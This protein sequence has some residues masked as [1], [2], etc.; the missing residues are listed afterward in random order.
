MEYAIHL[1][2]LACCMILIAAIRQ[3]LKIMDNQIFKSNNPI[4]PN[5]PGKSSMLRFIFIILAV[6]IALELL[7][8]A[9]TL[10]T[11]VKLVKKTPVAVSLSEGS[12]NLTTAK[13]VYKVG[14]TMPVL[15]KV[16]TGNHL[17]AGVD[18]VLKYDPSKLEASSSSLIKGNTY[19]DYPQINIDS[20]NGVL[21]TSGVVA[22]DKS[23]FNGKG[24]FGTINFTAKSPGVTTISL[25]FSP[26]ATTDSN[27]VES[28]TNKDVLGKVESVKINIQ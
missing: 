2:G 23:G 1:S 3:Y 13:G 8:G 27:M 14:E 25:E 17:T 26:N 9:K 12:I 16:S 15:I 10:F 22:P 21:R 24:D 19:D 4:S 18:L 5:P 28:I 11:P 6:V 7:L 20:K